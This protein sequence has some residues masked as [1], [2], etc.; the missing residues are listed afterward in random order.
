[1]NTTTKYTFADRVNSVPVSFIRE[2]LKVAAQPGIISFAGGLPNPDFFPVNEIAKAA[3]D[4][5]ATEG[6]TALQYAGTEGYLPLRQYIAERYRRQHNMEISPGNILITNGSQQALDLIGKVFLNP[7][8]DVLIESPSYL[9]AIQC[10]SMFQPAFTSIQLEADGVN[11]EQLREAGR[12]KSIKLFY[13]IPNYQ[14]P[15]GITYGLVKRKAVAAY[16][17]KYSLH[18]IIIED[19]PYGDIYFGGMPLKP[20][21]AFNPDQTILLGSFSKTVA[22]GM[23]LGWLV[24]PDKIID[25]LTVMKQASDLHSNNLAQHILYRYLIDNDFEAH[26][27]RIRRQYY[28]QKSTMV[29]LLKKYA[30]KEIHFVDAEGGMFL[31]LTLPSHIDAR[32]ILKDAIDEGVMFVP[33][34]VFYLAGGR[35]TIRLN[36][37]NTQTPKMEEGIRK[38]GQIL[39]K[40]II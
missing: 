30:P 37:S 8:D 38:L 26:L 17:A 16:F 10:L 24:A 6:A 31:W 27:G 29:R 34:D 14:N 20:I 32:A 1:M 21:K 7:G 18:T 23:R 15:T 22:P 9:G 39:Y 3:A 28:K 40:Y 2:I 5:L 25:K 36:F 11:T 19:D 13:C 35:N 4:V 12:G 33:G